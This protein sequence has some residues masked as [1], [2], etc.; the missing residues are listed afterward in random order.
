MAPGASWRSPGKRFLGQCA[1]VGGQLAAAARMVRSFLEE[2][3]LAYLRRALIRN[4]GLADSLVVAI[5]DSW[6]VVSGQDARQAPHVHSLTGLAGIYYLDCGL[7]RCAVALEDPR[8]PAATADLPGVLRRR[9]GFGERETFRLRTGSVLVHPSW[10]VHAAEPAPGVGERVAVSFTAS[11][12]TRRPAD[13]GGALRARGIQ[14]GSAE[15]NDE[16]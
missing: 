10:L 16:L 1:D 13:G 11:V 8:T 4:P 2:A 7:G 5:E 6:A 9:V 14:A 12:A 15:A 3:V